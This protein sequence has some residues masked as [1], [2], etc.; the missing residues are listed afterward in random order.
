MSS[1]ATSRPQGSAPVEGTVAEGGRR[2]QMGVTES[3]ER[4]CR[5]SGGAR[6]RSRQRMRGA[7]R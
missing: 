1:P 6:E 2:H 7:R 3:D 4:S 5:P